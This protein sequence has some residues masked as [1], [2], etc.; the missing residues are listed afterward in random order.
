MGLHQIRFYQRSR[1]PD[2][3]A[4][5]LNP[6]GNPRQEQAPGSES[7]SNVAKVIIIRHQS[8]SII[9][10]SLVLSASHSSSF[11]KTCITKQA[12][13]NQSPAPPYVILLRGHSPYE[14]SSAILF[15]RPCGV[16]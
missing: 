8:V 11:N 16:G 3:R 9:S 6:G 12:D 2:S 15:A 10:S 4:D 14:L 13:P 5:E 1:N 7:S